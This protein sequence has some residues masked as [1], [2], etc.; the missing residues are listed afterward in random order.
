MPEVWGGAH[1]KKENRRELFCRALIPS[2]RRSD[3][4]SRGFTIPAGS[5]KHTNGVAA[6]TRR[7]SQI[8]QVGGT[9]FPTLIVCGTE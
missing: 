3:W 2:D 4:N 1:G 6:M 9:N 8:F 7:D 5:R